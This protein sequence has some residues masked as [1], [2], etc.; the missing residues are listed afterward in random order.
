MV[1]GFTTWGVVKVWK[2]GTR[3]ARRAAQSRASGPEPPFV[4]PKGSS[5]YLSEVPRKHLMFNSLARAV[6]GTS[7]DRSLKAFQRRVPRINAHEPAISAMDDVTLRAQ[8]DAFRARL[9]AGESLDD[10]LPE[11]FATVREASRRVL[12][13]RHFDVQLVGGM[14]LHKGMHRR[15]EA[16]VKV[17]RWFATLRVLTLMR[18][19]AAKV[20]MS[21]PLTITSPK[22]DSA[23]MDGASCTSSSA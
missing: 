7:N 17:K 9:S 6:F 10:L 15:D 2:A 23:E 22:R 8:T 5:S 20:C 16:P 12:G 3:H 14:V 21:S 1:Q 13:M 4:D 11:A 19:P 18:L